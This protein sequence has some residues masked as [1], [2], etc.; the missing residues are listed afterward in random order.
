MQDEQSKR[1]AVSR[2]AGH[3]HAILRGQAT[4][5]SPVPPHPN[6]RPPAPPPDMLLRPDGQ[7]PM[8]PGM[9]M[10]QPP[11]MA[12]PLMQPYPTQTPQL[13]TP[14]ITVHGHATHMQQGM[15]P[16]QPGPAQT[17]QFPQTGFAPYPQHH[18]PQ[19]QVPHTAS[20]PMASPHLVHH[21]QSQPRQP[22]Y[23]GPPPQQT[24][25]PHH[26]QPPQHG[27]SA[28]PGTQPQ[29]PHAHPPGNGPHAAH[30]PSISPEAS[31][32]AVS[33]APGPSDGPQPSIPQP[34]GS[35]TIPITFS[36]PAGFDI[37]QQLRGPGNSYI[38]HIERET[39]A[40]IELRRGGPGPQGG[41]EQPMH[42]SIYHPEPWRRKPAEDLIQSLL[43][44]V[45]TA[46]HAAATPAAAQGALQPHQPHQH[47]ALFTHIPSITMAAPGDGPGQPASWSSVGSGHGPSSAQPAAYGRQNPHSHTPSMA[48]RSMFIQ[49]AH[50]APQGVHL[51]PA[52]AGPASAPPGPLAN[53]HHAAPPMPAAHAG[54][55]ASMPP[56]RPVP[57]A[58]TAPAS[59]SSDPGAGPGAGVEKPPQ[60][61]K[62]KFR[63]FKEEPRNTQARVRPRC[64]II[65]QCVER[66]GAAAGSCYTRACPRCFQ[67]QLSMHAGNGVALV[68]STP[69]R[70]R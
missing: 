41:A 51:M 19:Q 65:D 48:P 30:A 16:V 70:W 17:L 69:R 50:A 27:M 9:P 24:L 29:M 23:Q 38:T 20:H 66:W 13:H 32:F 34:S 35:C 55:P 18:P 2:A 3:I 46:A 4:P 39:G 40:T 56:N 28:P 37:E 49:P 42:I 63:E 61:V 1:I 11:Y 58:A 59:T 60:P 25:P 8:Q 53:G 45:Q 22:L 36:A 62:R 44:T 15:S 7:R 68:L 67:W 64:P 54:A 26:G 12:G 31:H 21:Q 47:T 43:Q 14:P 57:P 5:M 33:A 10:S 52:Q 6:S